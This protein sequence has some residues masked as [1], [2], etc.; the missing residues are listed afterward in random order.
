MDFS[1]AVTAIDNTPGI[2]AG[3]FSQ[4]RL[5]EGE[6][7]VS[8][9][10]AGCHHKDSGFDVEMPGPESPEGSRPK[11]IFTRPSMTYEGAAFVLG[12]ETEKVEE[13]HQTA[14]DKI[15][16]VKRAH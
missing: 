9:V 16:A 8:S 3:V 13:I 7:L 6:S 4:T 14:M 11:I 10:M 15:L 12:L 2:V 5:T 1:T